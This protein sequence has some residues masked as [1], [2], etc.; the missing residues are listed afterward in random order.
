MPDRRQRF[1]SAITPTTRCSVPDPPHTLT[2]EAWA[3][4]SDTQVPTGQ[5]FVDSWSVIQLLGALRAKASQGVERYDL[6][7]S[8]AF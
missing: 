7:A 1:Q 6:W 2:G 3:C 5:R 4:Q 8:D